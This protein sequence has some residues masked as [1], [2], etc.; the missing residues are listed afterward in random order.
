MFEIVETS[1]QG[2]YRFTLLRDGQPVRILAWVT[3][4]G[5]CLTQQGAIDDLSDDEL[6]DLM[7]KTSVR[8]KGKQE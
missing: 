4:F 2:A 1:H 3:P 7:R 8:I 6:L 5:K